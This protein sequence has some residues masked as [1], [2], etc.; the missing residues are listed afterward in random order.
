M[1]KTMQMMREWI[2]HRPSPGEHTWSATLSRC[3]LAEKP[4]FIITLPSSVCL[5]FTLHPP[6]SIPI[7]VL[8]HLFHVGATT[9]TTTVPNLVPLPNAIAT[10]LTTTIHS[11][12]PQCPFPRRPFHPIHQCRPWLP[13]PTLPQLCARYRSGSLMLE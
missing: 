3:S 2:Y 10:T 7:P 12:S 13:R 9:L 8:L 5:T 1:K 11:P 4:P 6:L